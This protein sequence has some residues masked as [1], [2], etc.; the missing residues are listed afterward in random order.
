V[1]GEGRKENRKGVREREKIG[2]G[3]RRKGEGW[4]AESE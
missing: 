3:K 1:G 4:G 2:R